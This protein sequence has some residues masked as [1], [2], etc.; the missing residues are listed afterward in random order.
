M[1]QILENLDISEKTQVI[2]ISG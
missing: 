1:F 2:N